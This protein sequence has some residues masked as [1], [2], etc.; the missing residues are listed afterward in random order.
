[1]LAAG[2]PASLDVI[3]ATRFQEYSGMNKPRLSETGKLSAPAPMRRGPV[4]LQVLP[5]LVTGGVER[6]TVDVAGAVVA[7][8]GTAIVVSAGGP[9]VHEL[10]RVGARHITL[11][12][13]SKNPLVMRRNVDRLEAIIRAE[14]VDLVHARSRAPAWSALAA[15]R[16][17]GVPFI[18]TFH[19]T[20]G[21]GNL[22]KRRYN[23]VMTK[24]ARII[25]IS[26]F[27][28]EHIRDVYKVDPARIR[29]IHRGV[30]L[31]IFDPAKVPPARIIQL[32][33]DWRLPDGAQV[34]ML[35][36]RLTRWKGQTVFLEA[37]AKLGRDDICAVVLGSD[38]GRTAYSEELSRLV[39]KLGLQ[40][41]VRFV[42]Q[43]RDMPAAYMLAD[44]VVSASTDPEAFGRVVTE[45]QAMGKPVIATDHGGARETVLEGQTGWLVPPGDASALAE[46]I[47]RALTLPQMDYR[48]MSALA[49]ATV[50][51]SFTKSGLCAATLALYRD[52]L[53]ERHAAPG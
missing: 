7:A 30:D 19:G 45:A 20:Y 31:S 11:P 43:C 50:R 10:E 16:R 12:V 6:G 41:V 33:R 2:P 18:T 8:G 28:A 4:I 36:G 39:E 27:I 49:T 29:V 13:D 52:V 53:A 38:Q 46:A 15:A 34:V 3:G 23:A 47:G 17:A 5:S 25:A 35:P 42:E 51:H 26:D 24:G 37:L 21:A 14:G 44:V 48:R 32:A 40:H 22:L 9:M 1:M